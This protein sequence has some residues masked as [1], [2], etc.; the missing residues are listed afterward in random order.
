MVEAR[1]GAGKRSHEAR[2]SGLR[3]AVL[4]LLAGAPLLALVAAAPVRAIEFVVSDIAVS[5][6]GTVDGTQVTIPVGGTVSI[7]GRVSDGSAQAIYGLGASYF[8]WNPAVL[9]F[10][11]GDTVGSL[12]HVLCIPGA[13]GFNGLTNYVVR[14]LAQT[15]VSVGGGNPGQ[16]RIRVLQAVSLNARAA[17]AADPGLDGTCGGG[18]AQ[19]RVTFSGTADGAT[20][21]TIGTGDDL[22]GRVVPG[23]NGVTTLAT[24][25]VV[26]ITVPEPGLGSCL[27]AA[28]LLA[29]L[30]ARSRGRSPLSRSR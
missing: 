11:S 3:R 27:A 8:G 12:F 17:N 20:S 21:I 19:F 15:V 23:L 10:E 18:D 6:G 9:A 22:G 13:G 16:P 30:A 25:A 29:A 26:T 24:N 7:G 14:P 1:R 2:S 4:G 5:A 28:S